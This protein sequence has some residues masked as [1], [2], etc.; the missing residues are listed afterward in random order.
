MDKDTTADIRGFLRPS[1][2]ELQRGLHEKGMKASKGDVA[3][4]MVHAATRL[5][6]SVVKALIEEYIAAE[7]AAYPSEV[8]E[9]DDETQ[10]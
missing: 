7:A 5:P 4:G 2:K 6:I 8:A 10:A 9:E 3:S 1:L